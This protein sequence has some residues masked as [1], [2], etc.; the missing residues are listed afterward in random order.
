MNEKKY[1]VAE[2]A[3]LA[4]ISKQAVYKQISNLNSQIQPYLDRSGRTVEIYEIAL[5]E[6]YNLKINHDIPRVNEVKPEIK[7]E[8]I[9]IDNP[10]QPENSTLNNQNSQVEVDYIQFLKEQVAQ[11]DKIIEELQQSIREKDSQIKDLTF[12][13]A[14]LAQQA[15]Q[16]A[17]QAQY[18]QANDKKLLIE[19]PLDSDN[20]KPS[21]W[22]RLKA[23]G[24]A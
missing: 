14:D 19:K 20:K 16:I 4:G 12:K 9:H 17:G 11:K 1:S 13:L 24:K 15:Q 23:R 3:K 5:T 8:E 6:I 21:F 22:A 18:L 10:E 2:F 7:P